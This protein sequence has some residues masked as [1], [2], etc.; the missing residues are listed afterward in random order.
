M[1]WENQDNAKEKLILLLLHGIGSSSHSNYITHHV[2]KAKNKGCMVVAMNFR[3]VLTELL[4][5]RVYSAND[6]E[7]LHFVLGHIK[8]LYPEHKVFAV[9]VSLG[10]LF[11]TFGFYILF[12][13]G[14]NLKV[15]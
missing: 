7:D 4:S 6:Q 5:S 12:I 9:G 11:L 1:D 10:N 15:A 8:K 3:G 13:F 2:N 14:F